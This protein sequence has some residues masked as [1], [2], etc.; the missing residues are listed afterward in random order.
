MKVIKSIMPNGLSYIDESGIDKFV[1]FKECNENWIKYR[2]RSENLTDEKVG[3]I[4]KNDKCIGQRDS[5]A[6]PPFIEFFTRPFTRFV[7]VESTEGQHP[8]QTFAQL[9]SEINS[10]GWTTFDLS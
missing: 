7:F 10:A 8:E 4:R 1:D 9:K 3:N 5:C 6:R 2:K